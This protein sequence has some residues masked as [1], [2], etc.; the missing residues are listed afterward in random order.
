VKLDIY[1]Q[2]FQVSLKKHAS[3]VYDDGGVCA[4]FSSSF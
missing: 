3:Y 1:V 2:T 4:S